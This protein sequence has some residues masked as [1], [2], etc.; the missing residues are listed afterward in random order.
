MGLAHCNTPSP[1]SGYGVREDYGEERGDESY[2]NTQLSVPSARFEFGQLKT[3]L[4]HTVIECNKIA[5]T[6]T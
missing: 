4:K 1:E 5:C 6:C 2:E 3:A